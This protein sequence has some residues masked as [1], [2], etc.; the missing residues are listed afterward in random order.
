[1][2]DLNPKRAIHYERN[3]WAAGNYR[4]RIASVLP[5]LA[6]SGINSINDAIEAHQSKL[7]V[8]DIPELFSSD[9]L[10]ALQ[11][12][13]ISAFGNACRYV[14]TFL[15]KK[16]IGELYDQVEWQYADQFWELLESCGADKHV[17][18]E[19][20]TALLVEHPRCFGAALGIPK[21]VRHFDRDIRKAIMGVPRA[22]A[23]AIIQGLAMDLQRRRSLQLPLSLSMADIDS[24]MLAYL[25]SDQPNPNYVEAL[26]RWPSRFVAVYKPSTEVCVRAK[27]VYEKS[28]SEIFADGSGVCFSTEVVIDMNQRACRGVRA[29]GLNL[30]CS[31]GGQWLEKYMDPA[32]VM[33]NCRWV[34]NFMDENGL[35]LMAA[36]EHEESSLVAILGPHVHGEYRDTLAA[37][38]RQSFAILEAQAYASFLER[39]GKSLEE[40]LEWV[41]GVYFHEEYGIDGFGISLPSKGGTWLDRCKGKASEIERAIKEYELYSKYGAIENEYLRYEQFRSFGDASALLE[42]KYAVAGEEF[43]VWANPLLSDQSLLSFVEGKEN[44]GYRSLFD[45]IASEDIKKDDYQDPF[46]KDIERLIEEALVTED[47]VTGRLEPTQRAMCLRKVWDSGAIVARRYG[48]KAGADIEGLVSQGLL[49]YHD[50]LFTPDEA[51]F[52]NYMLNDSQQTN[53]I[54]LRNKYSHASGLIKDPNADE[55][56]FDYYTMLALLVSITLKINDELLEVKWSPSGIDFVDWPFNDESVYE[57]AAQFNKRGQTGRGS[58][59][60]M[61]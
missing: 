33:N 29:D 47:P 11:R 30:S 12:Y 56:R 4:E 24:V 15:D 20:L 13:A 17:D 36:H 28:M 31:F 9:D 3:D 6:S 50:G 38:H 45:L 2:K 49:K 26:T 18:G 44:D 16:N 53:A 21:F 27:Q 22:S 43:L 46:R 25:N 60:D 55:I 14:N 7:T 1:M 41:Y 10:P 54:G 61:R 8:E 19:D 32:T 42:R 58:L 5:V 52:L 51:S 57:T 23:E 40:V 39:R 48:G 59:G 35:M 37:R 34:F